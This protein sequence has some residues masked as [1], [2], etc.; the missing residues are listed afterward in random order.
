[1]NYYWHK[2][3][4]K[5]RLRNVFDNN[6]SIDLKVSKAQIFKIVQSEGFLRWLLS[7]GAVP[8]MKVA[9]PFAKNVLA[10]LGIK[11]LP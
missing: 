10:P 4:Q 8:L 2:A 6:V 7:K 11:Q 5:V 1:M 3:R 9:I